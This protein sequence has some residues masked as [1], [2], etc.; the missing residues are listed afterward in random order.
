MQHFVIRPGRDITRTVTSGVS[1]LQCIDSSIGHLSDH[2]VLGHDSHRHRCLPETPILGRVAEWMHA[3]S[4]LISRNSSTHSL[5]LISCGLTLLP[6]ANE[7]W[8]GFCYRILI[9]EYNRHVTRVMQSTSA[10]SLSVMSSM[11]CSH[12]SFFTGLSRSSSE[13][14]PKTVE[15]RCPKM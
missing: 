9:P 12:V 4:F 6:L 15:I 13:S 8:V 1:H 5:P 7:H 2:K 11:I 3:T 14:K 10:V